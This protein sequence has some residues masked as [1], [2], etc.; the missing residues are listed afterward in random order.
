MRRQTEEEKR[1][2]EK[3]IQKEAKLQAQKILK[4]EELKKVKNVVSGLVT[5]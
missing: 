1:K 4:E 5:F 2:V 3:L